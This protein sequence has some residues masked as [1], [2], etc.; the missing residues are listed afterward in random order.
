MMPPFFSPF[1]NICRTACSQGSGMFLATLMMWDK[2]PQILSMWPSPVGKRLSYL[3][4]STGA[5]K[6]SFMMTKKWE[7]YCK[8]SF[9]PYFI[10]G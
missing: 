8:M 2:D 5:Q 6:K 4:P 1:S 7:T 3:I 9:T 10:L